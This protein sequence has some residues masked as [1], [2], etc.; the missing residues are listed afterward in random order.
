MQ[1]IIVAVVFS[2]VGAVTAVHGQAPPRADVVKAARQVIEAARYAT[3]ATIDD[4]GGYPNTRIVDPFPPE[5]DFTIWIG[6]NAAT[7]KVQQIGR[8]PR[9]SLVYFDAPRQHYVS[10]IGAAT[11]VRD[12]AERA[13]RFKPE[14]NAFYKNG[15]AGDDYV[16]LRV[17]PLKLEIVAESLGMK[18]DPVTWRPVSIMAR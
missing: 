9:V 6:T 10:I 17:D 12:P 11:V 15:S 3:L 8:N 2:I 13:R 1:R 14:W 18:S 16:L 5:H 7:R 4:L